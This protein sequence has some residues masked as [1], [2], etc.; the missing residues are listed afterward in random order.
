MTPSLQSQD[1]QVEII[2]AR[3]NG[4]LPRQAAPT[5]TYWQAT[6]VYGS[7]QNQVPISIS[8]LSIYTAPQTLPSSPLPTVSFCPHRSVTFSCFGVCKALSA[9]K[10]ILFFLPH[11]LLHMANPSRPRPHFLFPQ[12]LPARISATWSCQLPSIVEAQARHYII[13]VA[14][15][16]QSLV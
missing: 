5:T 15:P 7:L 2:C 3:V 9:E 13:W 8:H 12:P 4:I 14:V 6:E 10:Y 16:S 11:L 1:L